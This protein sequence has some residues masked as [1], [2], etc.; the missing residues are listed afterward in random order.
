MA[1]LIWTRA[2]RAIHWSL[3][4]LMA[5]DLSLLEVGETPHRIAGTSMAVLVLL[6]LGIAL[7]AKPG[8]PNHYARLSQFWP[9]WRQLKTYVARFD[10][11][12]PGHNPLGALMVVWLWALILATAA[13]GWLQTLDAFWGEDWTELLHQIC[14]YSLCGS[15]GL[16]I[17]AVLVLER[18]HRPGLLRAIWRGYR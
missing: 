7:G 18:R 3:A 9:S 6:R 15:I 17:T 11:Q 10:H 12:T 4:T 5:A 1:Q 16:H 8:G 2:V 13:S 14:A